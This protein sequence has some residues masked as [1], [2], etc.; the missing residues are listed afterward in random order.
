MKPF[1]RQFDVGVD[2]RSFRPVSLHEL[3]ADAPGR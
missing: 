2:A 1:K 3:L